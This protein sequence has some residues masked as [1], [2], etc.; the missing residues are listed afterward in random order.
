MPGHEQQQFAWQ[1]Y[2]YY[3]SAPK[4]AAS[5]IVRA[6]SHRSS[7][8]DPFPSPRVPSLPERAGPV[9]PSRLQFQL[10]LEATISDPIPGTEGK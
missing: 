4:N 8:G 6:K 2:A 9:Q 5:C 1:N 3:F 7:Q 10:Q